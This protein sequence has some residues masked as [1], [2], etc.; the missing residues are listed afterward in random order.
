MSNKVVF[1]KLEKEN[2]FTEEFKDLRVNNEIE[3]SN[4]GIAVLYGPNGVGKTSLTKVLAGEKGTSFEVRYKDQDFNEKNNKLFHVIADQN[5]RNII[6]G[7]TKDFI[8]GENIRRE[9]ELKKQIDS[10][11]SMVFSSL[12]QSLKAD[13]MITKKAN[14]IISRIKDGQIKSYVSDLV[15]NRS[16]GEEIKLE[17]Y[18]NVVVGLKE[19]T[20]QDYEDKCFEFIMS[21]YEQSKPII[22]QIMN[23][24]IKVIQKEQN[25]RE[26][27]ENEYAINILNKFCYT[28]DC[29][30]C[31]STDINYEELIIKKD[32]NKKKV[33]A[34]LSET[35]KKITGDIIKQI[36]ESDPLDTKEILLEAMINGDGEMVIELQE[37][38][39]GIFEIFNKR[40]NNLFYGVMKTSKLKS[41]YDEYQKMLMSK[42]EL[43]EEDVIFIEK[44]INENIGRNIKLERDLSNNIM[45]LI[46][47]KQLIGTERD[48]LH[49][50]TGEQNF[51]SLAFEFLKAKNVPQEIIV[52]DDPISSFDSIY[53][54]KIAF[55][56]LKILENKKQ[57][58]LTH[59]LELVRLLEVQRNKCFKFYMFNNIQDEENGFIYVNENEQRILLY[60]DKLLDLIRNDIENHILN[61]EYFLIAMV[62]FMR[63]YANIVNKKDEKNNLT[64]VMHGYCN[65][66]VNLT[67]IYNELFDKSLDQIYEVSAQD[68]ISI[69]IDNIDILNEGTYPLL[70]KTLKHTLTYLFLRLSVENKLCT[71][72]PNETDGAELLGEII[73]KAFRSDSSHDKRIFFTSKKTLLNEFNHFEGNMNIFQPA[74]DIS[75]SALAKEKADII[76]YLNILQ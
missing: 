69:D 50:S 47:D 62:P 26:I 63:G 67:D 58:I 33:F 23:I 37:K 9:V 72:Y 71:L 3:F 20:I 73:F 15:N 35:A 19:Q 2:I 56:I 8:L 21:D 30:V 66:K 11:K 6:N 68:I 51:I 70:N 46:D 32:S 76:N 13:F 5:G 42:L 44:I 65:E 41:S 48:G 64:K 18:V 49:L 43:S 74:I 53:K 31:D 54:N 75:D 39:E 12:K 36:R 59:N 22:E 7:E 45:I 52:L 34:S 57:I 14:K 29:I 61:M 4:Q 40:I 16:N 1:K 28:K 17:E 24:D 27:E 25:I 60:I 38:I 10:E 55:S